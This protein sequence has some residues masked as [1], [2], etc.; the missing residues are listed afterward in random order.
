[1]AARERHPNR[2]IGELLAEA[3]D[4]LPGGPLDYSDRA[5]NTI[6]SPRHFVTVRR[7]LGGPAPE[8]TTRAAQVSRLQLEADERWHGNATG[9]LAQAERT[10]AERSATL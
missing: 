10:L 7:T 6:L 8:E 1:M 2:S 4:T 3:S 9:A 5:L